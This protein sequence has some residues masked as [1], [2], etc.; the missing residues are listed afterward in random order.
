MNGTKIN[1]EKDKEDPK[2]S[3]LKR[4]AKVWLTYLVSSIGISVLMS[5]LVMAVPVWINYELG[6]F[7]WAFM[8]S[9]TLMVFIAVLCAVTSVFFV[10][11]IIGVMGDYGVFE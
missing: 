4:Y 1:K 3:E 11:F 8:M 6:I 5:A 7:N 2:F 9:V 10:I